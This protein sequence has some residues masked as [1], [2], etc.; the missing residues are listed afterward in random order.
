M[1]RATP[2]FIKEALK[3]IKPDP[4][5]ER[6][7]ESQLVAVL[8]GIEAAARMDKL[9][10]VPTAAQYKKNLLK[11][12]KTLQDAIELTGKAF[13]PEYQIPRGKD[14]WIRE[15]LKR[16]LE[17]TERV[18]NSISKVVRKA[19]I[20]AADAAYILLR[21]Y[22]RSPTRVGGREGR[23]HKL[24]KVLFGNEDADLFDYLKRSSPYF[25]ETGRI[26]PES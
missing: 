15:H 26:R 6:E 25:V 14:S 10:S 16:H 24:A 7:C 19:R 8:S 9:K 1:Y 13:P 21:Q 17:E 22:G 5:R 12:A 23:T 4:E 3:I 2:Q 11:L 20:A 18:I